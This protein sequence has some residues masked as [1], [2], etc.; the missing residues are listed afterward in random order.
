MTKT[1]INRYVFNTAITRS[2][3]L[4][5]AVGNPLTLL[6]K[7]DRMCQKDPKNEEY[8]CW[9]QYIR[10][11]IECKSFHLPPSLNKEKLENFTKILHKKVFDLG[12][13]SADNLLSRRLSRKEDSILQAY[14]KKFKSIPDCRKSQ[15]MLSKIPGRDIGWQMKHFSHATESNKHEEPEPECTDEYEEI[16]DCKLKVIIYYKAEGIPLKSRKQIVHI[17]GKK[18][19]QGAFDE[20]IVRV[21]VFSGQQP[22]KC[23]GKVLKVL[24]KCHQEKLLCRVHKYNPVW[25]C[26]VSKKYPM[27]SNIPHRSKVHFVKKSKE[28]IDTELKSKDVAIFDEQS[29]WNDDIP[30]VSNV[31]PHS[32]ALNMLFIVRILQWKPKYHLPLGIAIHALPVGCSGF[33][34]ERILKIL[35]DV[36]YDEEDKNDLTAPAAQQSDMTGKMDIRAF[37]I[38]PQDAVNLDDAISLTLLPK[39]AT[40]SEQVYQLA[41]YIVNTCK[42]IKY[43]DEIDFK[44]CSLGISV[45]SKS[46]RKVMNMLPSNVR[47]QLSLQPG[48]TRDVFCVSVKITDTNGDISID[49]MEEICDMQ[50]KSC[51]KLSYKTAQD[52]MDGVINPSTNKELAKWLS[53][54][55]SD[56]SQLS[57]KGTLCFLYK[58]AIKLR[59]QRLGSLAAL[60]Y[61]INESGEEECWQTHLM[62]EELMV[63]ANKVISTKIFENFPHCALLRKQNAPNHQELAAISSQHCL[64][65]NHSFSLVKY[66]QNLEMPQTALAI[67]VQTLQAMLVA[68]TEGKHNMLTHLLTASHL[69]PQLAACSVNFM[70]LQ[71]KAE[72]CCTSVDEETS[73]YSHYSLNLSTYTHFTSPLRRYTDIIV[74]RMIMSLL[75]GSECHY[76][77]DQTDE[78]C[79]LLNAAMKNSKSFEK[80]MNAMNLALKYSHSSDVYDV[81]IASSTGKKIEVCFP[82]LEMKDIPAHQK[83]ISVKGL[84]CEIKSAASNQQATQLSRLQ[85]VEGNIYSWSVKLLFLENPSLLFQ[86]ED[87]ECVTYVSAKQQDQ[88]PHCG[89]LSFPHTILKTFQPLHESSMLKETSHYVSMSPTAV[90]LHPKEW[91]K[92][93]SYIQHP[94][95]RESKELQSILN[96]KLKIHPKQ[97]KDVT[98]ISFPFMKCDVS[99]RMD[100]NDMTRVWMTWSTRDAILAPQIQMV[101]IAP[102][103][104]V[105]V[106]HNTHPAECFSESQLR[107][108]SKEKYCNI[109]EYVALWERVL[110][111]EAAERSVKD[112]HL[113]IIFD[114]PLEWPELVIPKNCL[115]DIYYVPKGFIELAMPQN[116]IESTKPFLKVHVGDMLCVRYGTK[117]NSDIRAVFHMVVSKIFHVKSKNDKEILLLKVIGEDNCRISDKMRSII[118]EKCEIQVISMSPSYQ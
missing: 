11:C 23:F 49:H 26:P 68:L 61:D 71:Q 46:N 117:K 110:L 10:R 102:F 31:I 37:T 107:Q 103:L 69:Y 94:S 78:I 97:T 92:F 114:V 4:V 60:S 118:K 108:A 63:W 93:T 111:A 115:D 3:Y 6:E 64:V 77:H 59:S 95:E 27:L 18:N 83:R 44:A 48:Q 84:K 36:T 45:Y 39:T 105:C 104:R 28:A 1:L 47:R 34:N 54:F 80:E 87:L 66:S 82:Q 35:H 56:K 76:S 20:D 106:Q 85:S 50:V 8:R 41:V 14:K 21:G 72:Y 9:K 53:N 58:V 79:H 13:V 98:T 51:A 42:L 24:K 25:F 91:S 40:D 75:N 57:L 74:Q 2:K 100:M 70:K 17:H 86:H 22:E 88:D 65:L 12:S 52:I 32:V 15:L 16:Y 113:A 7:E 81:Y 19:I 33:H 5:V 99:C 62:V 38:D 55:E 67:P 43:E 29:L 73:A 109:Q 112:S 96:S 89:V 90:I 116:I 101:E 30:Q